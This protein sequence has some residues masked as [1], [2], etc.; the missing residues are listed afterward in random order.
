MRRIKH[1]DYLEK[2]RTANPSV[3]PLEPYVNMKTPIMHKC[4]IHGT[5]WKTTPS[6][7]LQGCGCKQCSSEKI[8]KKLSKSYDRYVLDLKQ[9]LPHISVVGEYV[10]GSIPVLHYCEKHNVY[11]NIKPN[12]LLY[13]CG[14]P[15]CGKE[16]NVQ[17][18][19]KTKEWFIEEL[20]KVN[21]NVKLIGE[22]KNLNTKTMFYCEIHDEYW[23]TI[24]QNVLSGHGCPICHKEKTTLK[25]TKTHEQYV[26]ELSISN[27][28]IEVVGQY[29]NAHVPILHKCKICGHEWMAKPNN[30][31]NNNRGCPKCQISNGER[32]I[33]QLLDKLGVDY[34][35]Q[36]KFDACRHK[37]PLPFDFYLKNYNIAIEYQGEQHY[38]PVDIFGGQEH[39]EQQKLHDEIKNEYCYDNNIQ[40]ITIP[41]WEF[42]NI[43][44]IILDNLKLYN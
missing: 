24:P 44:N 16:Q 30:V 23:I 8:R 39:F 15:E 12:D 36:M 28:D 31:F 4:L 25:T 27:P 5:E 41:Y 18:C 7:V 29:V 3:V 14:C 20:S 40:L 10:N 43:E 32:V 22:Y 21:P 35:M 42:N 19:L 9:A 1:E 33:A 2:L 34:T 6:S 17:W 26:Y 38:R 11:W 13:R 37:R